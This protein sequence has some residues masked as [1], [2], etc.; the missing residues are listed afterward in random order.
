VD[1]RAPLGSDLALKKGFFKEKK[2]KTFFN[3]L[4]L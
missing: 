3:S 4:A 1:D 2:N